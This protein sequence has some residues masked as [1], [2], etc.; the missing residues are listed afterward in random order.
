M[1]V[2][3]AAP[4]PAPRKNRLQGSYNISNPEI[5]ISL[6]DYGTIDHDTV[7]V[8]FNGIKMAD[9]QELTSSPLRIH[10]TANPEREYQELILH[11]NNLG[12]I[13]PNTSKM[14]IITSDKRYE[15]RVTSSETENAMIRFRYIP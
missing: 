1:P 10:L 9:R 14:V 4:A 11:A 7:T 12:D 13:P 3:S 6:Y 2:L 15:L 5:D 8:F